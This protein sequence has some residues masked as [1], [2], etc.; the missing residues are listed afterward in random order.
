MVGILM[1][2]G[3]HL[4]DPARGNQKM[5]V[6]LMAWCLAGI[7]FCISMFVRTVEIKLRTDL[8]RLELALAELGEQVGR[9]PE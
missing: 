3:W 2:Q 5:L 8:L 7:P 9:R 4:P 1:W 6:A